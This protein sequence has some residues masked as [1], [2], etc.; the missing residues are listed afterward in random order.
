M[1]VHF[2]IGL[3]ISA[4]VLEIWP[5]ARKKNWNGTG[6]VY[7][8]A[9]G[10]VVSALF[11]WLLQQGGDYDGQLIDKHQL[12]GFITAGLS[13]ITALAYYHREK[14]PDRLPVWILAIT[15]ISTTIAGHLGASI[16]HGTDYLFPRQSGDTKE[17]DKTAVANT[18]AELT[19]LDESDTLTVQQLDRL[20]LQARAIFAHNCYQCHST[21]KR[22]GG[23]ALDHQEGVFAGGDNGAVLEKGYS[24]Q[25]EMIRRLKLPRSDEESMPPKGKVLADE[26]IALLELWIDKGAHW[27]DADLKVFHEAELALSKPD[28]PPAPPDITHPIDQFVNDYFQRNDIRWPEL[29]NDRQFLRRAFLDI[30]GI[31][32]TPQEIEDFEK[33]DRIDKRTRLIDHLLDDRQSYT[34]N[35]LSFWNDLLRND[36]SGTGFITGG[37][38]QITDWLYRSLLN[39]KPYNKMVAELVNP[40]PESEGFIKGI[41]WRGV[42]NASQ[43]TELQAA[44]NISQSLLGLNLKCASCHN[45]FINNLTLDEAYGFANIFSIEP[46]EINRC[47]KPTG[48]MAKTSF[49]YPELGQVNADSLQDRLA[50]LAELITKPENG[51]L[52]RTVVNRYWD[53]LFGRGIVAPVDEMDNVPW[54][55][56]LLDWLAYDFIENGYDFQHLLATIMTSQTYQLS[57]VPYSSPTSLNAES[58]VFQGPALRRLTVE[59][60]VDAFSQMITPF[61]YSVGYDPQPDSIHPSWIWHGEVEVDRI[62]VPKPG[63]RFF[64]KTFVIVQPEHVVSADVL[65]TADDQFELY[66]NGVPIAE[67]NDWRNVQHITIPIDQI[68]QTN[69]IAVAATNDGPISNPAGL[70]FT[71]RLGSGIALFSISILI[72]HGEQRLIQQS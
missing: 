28:L 18:L 11:G 64:R 52:Y 36:Y 54:S 30:K 65:V 5:Y 59:Q 56:E 40:E 23:L 42:V 6:I 71:L 16:T 60:F 51:R 17:F 62:N 49:L 50:Q 13:I 15:C 48:R 44:Q 21:A 72:K 68:Q 8:G 9:A 45:S 57:A 29:I 1:V 24:S 22:K 67:G 70:L 19:P 69:V 32:P 38:K 12:W 61:Y 4:L 58:F 53:R 47:D 33:D 14:L 46:L 63:K 35:W 55:Q 27:A 20:N 66:F 34:L 26:E 7:L 43:R 2:P 41:Q 37:R 25:S 10:G 3:L 31:L 39:Q